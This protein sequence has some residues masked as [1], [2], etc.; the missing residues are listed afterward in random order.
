MLEENLSTYYQSQDS[1]IVTSD[2]EESDEEDQLV[3]NKIN[4]LWKRCGEEFH[5]TATLK[6]WI[7]FI[8]EHEQKNK[9]VVLTRE[10]K[11]ALEPFCRYNMELEMEP[12]DFGNLLRVI[13]KRARVTTDR[14]SMDHT[15]DKPSSPSSPSSSSLPPIPPPPVPPVVST[16]AASFASRP[17]SSDLLGYP[18]RRPHISTATHKRSTTDT[19]TDTESLDE[20]SKRREEEEDDYYEDDGSEDHPSVHSKIY[21]NTSN[22]RQMY[23]PDSSPE[24]QKNSLYGLAEQSNRP[25]DTHP[26]QS[27]YAN[28]TNS[29]SKETSTL[30][31]SQGNDSRMSRLYVAECERENKDLKKCLE[32]KLK[33]VEQI[34]R[35]SDEQIAQLQSELDKARQKITT[36]ETIMVENKQTEQYQLEQMSTLEN[37]LSSSTNVQAQQKQMLSQAKTQFEDKCVELAKTKQEMIEIHEQLMR[38][39][40]RWKNGQEELKLLLQQREDILVNQAQL[41]AALAEEGVVRKDYENLQ[42]VNHSLQEIIDRLKL[43]L[44][45]AKNKKHMFAFTHGQTLKTEMSQDTEYIHVKSTAAKE[46]MTV[47]EE[48]HLREELQ[49]AEGKW[50]A[51]QQ[52]LATAVQNLLKKAYEE[53]RGLKERLAALE[54]LHATQHEALEALSKKTVDPI[55]LEKSFSL[56]PQCMENPGSQSKAIQLPEESSKQG[57]GILSLL[58]NAMTQSSLL[59]RKYSH[60]WSRLFVHSTVNWVMYA[61]ALYGVGQF[62]VSFWSFTSSLPSNY[63][64]GYYPGGLPPLASHFWFSGWVSGWKQWMLLILD[65]P[66]SRF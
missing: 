23:S 65:E 52:E 14:S 58:S 55:T 43:E 15:T 17:R 20:R 53:K 16:N 54:I 26:K 38:I 62:A 47:E 35:S 49:I 37:R 31:H 18:S 7:Q 9:C 60:G 33:E 44:E 2:A 11:K 25:I 10:Q 21:Q 1:S 46:A 40:L 45:D 66:S 57:T 22:S 42:S 13:N 8:G 30:R 32:K 59:G 41:E 5:G 3:M 34:A 27:T 6:Q 48:D 28:K 19:E 12:K 39:E 4:A 56:C 50:T 63:Y 36:Y 64:T 24:L 61:L 51:C 29:H